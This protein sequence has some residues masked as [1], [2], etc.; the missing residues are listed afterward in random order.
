MSVSEEKT[1]ATLR[2][3]ADATNVYSFVTEYK[4]M[5]SKIAPEERPTNIII[6]E[7][8]R[9]ADE[10]AYAMHIGG[11]PLR[12]H[13]LVGLLEVMKSEVINNS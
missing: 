4:D 2:P 5:I 1:V 7:H 6:V 11:E 12:P 13:H 9:K 10:T 8:Y 3:K